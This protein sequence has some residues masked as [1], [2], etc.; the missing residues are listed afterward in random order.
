MK[1]PQSK[2]PNSEFSIKVAVVNVIHKRIMVA[3]MVALWV[4]VILPSAFKITA[5]ASPQTV[6]EVVICP[7]MFIQ[8]RLQNVMCGF[9]KGIPSGTMLKK[10]DF[11]HEILPEGSALFGKTITSV[12]AQVKQVSDQSAYNDYEESFIKFLV[13]NLVHDYISML[14]TPGGWLL[15][16]AAV[17][18]SILFSIWSWDRNSVM[19]PNV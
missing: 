4:E 19:T 9:G 18:P 3:L 15:F 6:S 11:V 7:T 8:S 5:L 10:V 1:F 13:K 17:W 16:L 2:L 14:E 12:S